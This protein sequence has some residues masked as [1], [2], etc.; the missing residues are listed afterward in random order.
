MSVTNRLARF[1]E[2][3]DPDPEVADRPVTR[4]PAQQAASRRN[5]KKSRGPSSK[6]GKNRSRLNSLKDGFFTVIAPSHDQR[7]LHRSLRRIRQQL[8]DD[9]GGKARLP[10]VAIALIDSLAHDIL[11]AGRARRMVEQLHQSLLPSRP[12]PDDR[13]RLAHYQLLQRAR[14]PISDAIASLAKGEPPRLRSD[15]VDVVAFRLRMIVDCAEDILEPLPETSEP[16]PPPHLD[17]MPALPMPP[18]VAS[19][20][21]D[22]E[23][24]QH[25]AGLKRHCG[26]DWDR[27]FD[28]DANV[29]LLKSTRPLK[30]TLAKRLC[31][32]LAE[33]IRGLE[34][35]TA[36]VEQRLKQQAKLNAD[37]TLRHLANDMERLHGLQ[38]YIAK[39]ER[40]I[41]TRLARI[42]ALQFSGSF[43][44]FPNRS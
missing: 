44:R 18:A 5:G 24:V 23:E 28:I 22:D 33:L 21:D 14:Q 4:S 20:A 2:H 8:L 25:A 27:F 9:F 38:D 13:F 10:F 32:L 37:H 41:D 29:V 16:L 26:S 3:S 11:Q 35:M 12:T 42:A 6:A 17:G 1:L 43:F 19:S 36:G 39:I 34:Q 31:L 30:P 40:R 7:D 15:L